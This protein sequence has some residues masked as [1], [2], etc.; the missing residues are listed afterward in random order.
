MRSSK[1]SAA[2]RSSWRRRL[3][4]ELALL[5]AVTAALLLRSSPL[6][7]DPS[8]PGRG[9]LAAATSTMVGDP[10]RHNVRGQLVLV[11]IGQQ[12]AWMCQEAEQLLTTPVTNGDVAAGD[13]TPTGTWVV[14]DKETDRYLTGPGYVDYVHF[15]IP[16]SGDYG[17]HDAA[18]QTIPFGSPQYRTRGSHGCVH[19]PTPAMSWLYAWLAIGSRVTIQT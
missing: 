13:A 3:M 10:C 4:V 5:A 12:R 6:A 19:L 2:S 1:S 9:R 14:Q 18:W 17:L 11:S 15:W 16:V 8:G 7:R